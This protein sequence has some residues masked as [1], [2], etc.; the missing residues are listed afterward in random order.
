MKRDGPRLIAIKR[1]AIAMTF[2]LRRHDECS[3]EKNHQEDV[4]LLVRV[5]ELLLVDE[6]VQLRRKPEDQQG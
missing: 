4:D 6:I 1:P 2:S 3:S 5:T